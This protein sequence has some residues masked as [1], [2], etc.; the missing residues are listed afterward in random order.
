MD[1][2][3]SWKNQ[4]VVDETLLSAI[5]ELSSEAVWTIDFVTGKRAWIASEENRRKFNIPA[6]TVSPDD[7][8]NGLHPDYRDQ[9]IQA[10]ERALQNPRASFFQHEYLFRGRDHFYYRI[11][12]SMR[13]LRN[14]EGVAERVVGVWRDVTE[15]RVREQKLNEILNDLEKGR[16]RFKMFS[17]VSN[18]AMWEV[19]FLTSRVYWTAGSNTLEDLGLTKEMY[20]LLDWED[21]VHPEDRDRVVKHFQDTV[22]SG[23][24]AYFDTYRVMK[25]DGTVAYM[26]DQGSIVRDATGQAVRAFG[27]WTN[28][29]RERERE[30]VLE[31]ALQ[32][33]RQL[34]EALAASEEAQRATNEQLRITLQETASREFLLNQAQKIARIGSWEYNFTTRQMAWSEE[35]YNIYS[36]PK[37]YNINDP[38]LYQQLFVD[39]GRWLESYVQ[40]LIAQG[41]PFDVTLQAFTPIG[42]KKWVRIVGFPIWAND[43]VVGISGVTH[44]ITQYKESEERLR[45][46]EE[47]F[48][49]AF[50]NNPELMAICREADRVVIDVNDKILPLLGYKR[51]EVIGYPVDNFNLYVNEQDRDRYLETYYRDKQVQ[52][53][54]LWRRKDGRV[55]DVFIASSRIEIEGAYYTLYVIQDISKRKAAEERFTKAFDLGP[56]L[57]LIFRERDWALLEVN[58]KLTPVGGY[59]REEVIG[60]ASV[61]FALWA[62]PDDRKRYIDQLSRSESAFIE[63]PL[64]KKDGSVYFGAVSAKRIQLSS[65]SHI[66]VVVRDITEKR[67]VEEKIRQSE[68]NLISTINNTSLMVWSVDRDSRVI[69]YN[70]PLADFVYS[71]YGIVLREGEHIV[72]Y[73]ADDP[74][75]QRL[76]AMWDERYMRALAGETYRITDH[77]ELGFFDFSVSPIIER[78]QIIGVS[79]FGEDVTKQREDEASLA[80]AYKQIGELRLVALRSVMNPHFIFNALN[81]I[82]YFIAQNDRKNA[83]NYLSTF[84]KLIRGILTNSVNTKIKLHEELEQLN[85]YIQLELMRFENKFKFVF[86]V[87]EDVDTENI[88]IPSLLIQPYVENA[89]LHGLYNKKETGTLRIAVL[90]EHDTV[91]FEIEDDGVGRNEAM[92]LRNQN[93]P[94][95]KSMGTALTEERL[96]LINE[97]ENVA[98][99]TIDLF[100]ADNVACGTRVKIRVRI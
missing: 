86:D 11:A 84:S 73:R 19:D 12:D 35:L 65:E 10:F 95:H 59:M 22:N 21:A 94:K 69:T 56:D 60:K 47:K 2:A 76:R 13:F 38:H 53:E 42:Y 34:N 89:I 80:E 93:F 36:L 64:L 45:A 98:V 28:I 37:D 5:F 25:A 39:R 16:D 90:E 92:R 77:T 7:W 14:S 46:S 63:A 87:A 41:T 55:V 91:L 48:S 81:S 31:N 61:D 50:R 75:S 9:A 24:D 27:T 15:T 85:H 20:S 88:E 72:P 44:D 83:I 8:V 3:N 78:D 6:G 54:T 99:E 17:E 100:D 40:D 51:Q 71:N 79:V 67:R 58:S 33:Q 52:L 62:D 66:L 26:I 4:S 70:R 49:Q 97:R 43:K 74:E 18:A 29:T 82:Q 30:N 1:G 57:M 96:K 32:R 68:A 23:G